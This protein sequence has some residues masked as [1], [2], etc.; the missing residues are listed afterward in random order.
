M[1]LPMRDLGWVP[2]SNVQIEYR[3]GA[4]D[5]ERIRGYVAELVALNTLAQ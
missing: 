2:G 3:W 5:V 4:G 1:P